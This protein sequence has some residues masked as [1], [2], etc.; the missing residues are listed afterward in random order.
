MT[1]VRTWCEDPDSFDWACDL[2]KLSHAADFLAIETLV[3]QCAMRI[4]DLMR[5]GPGSCAIFE[6]LTTPIKLKCLDV[7]D[8]D[9]FLVLRNFINPYRKQYQQQLRSLLHGSLFARSVGPQAA[10]NVYE[11]VWTVI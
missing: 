5:R 11:A 7:A 3:E 10:F 9:W 1:A 2:A 8:K 6:H 4:N